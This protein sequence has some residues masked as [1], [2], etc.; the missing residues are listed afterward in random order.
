M[1]EVSVEHHNKEEEIKAEIK[2]NEEPQAEDEFMAREAARLQRTM[3]NVGKAKDRPRS[4]SVK[5]EEIDKSLVQQQ[6][7]P[8]NT[9]SHLAPVV[10]HP[11]PVTHSV[12]VHV[13]KHE[14]HSHPPAHPIPV[15]NHEPPSPIP[16][17]P[18]VPKTEEEKQAEFERQAK[19]ES[20]RF[21]RY[22]KKSSDRKVAPAISTQP[23]PQQP[24][25]P[26][27]IAPQTSP[28]QAVMLDIS[29]S[30]SNKAEAGKLATFIIKTKSVALDT[31]KS[32]INI[33]V[34]INAKDLDGKAVDVSNTVTYTN[35]EYHVSYTPFVIGPHVID[36]YV[37]GHLGHTLTVPVS[38]GGPHG[39]HTEAAWDTLKEATVGNKTQLIVSP[40]SFIKRVVPLGYSS[41]T[42]KVEH[43]ESNTPIKNVS[44]L[45]QPNNLYAVSF[46]PSQPGD[47]IVSVNLNGQHISGSP[48]VFKVNP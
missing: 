37:S 32:S 9:H 30:G 20:E 12:D 45:S 44:V 15:V 42:A 48:F 23:V 39:P 35:D 8:V 11:A 43:V 25:A 14:E 24:L 38:E 26:K 2:V 6:H 16:D 27:V 47:H 31:S 33:T 10:P 19:M 41:L 1:S 18:D 17:E 46:Y 5:K 36:I 21:E 13:T 22:L 28:R 3:A 7:E 34:K 40:M 4:W 29:G